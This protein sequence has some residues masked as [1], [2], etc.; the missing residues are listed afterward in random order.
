MISIAHSCSG[1]PTM[2]SMTI[3]HKSFKDTPCVI[4]TKPRIMRDLTD[5]RRFANSIFK[6]DREN[7]MLDFLRISG[8][9]VA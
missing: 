7:L 8:H 9:V 2:K 1:Y 3:N 6:S 5:I 4:R